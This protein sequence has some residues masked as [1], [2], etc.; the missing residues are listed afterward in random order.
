M[1]VPLVLV[2]AA[3]EPVP[4]PRFETVDASESGRVLALSG[5]G[6]YTVVSSTAASESVPGPGLWRI[7]RR[8]GIFEEETLALVTGHPLGNKRLDVEPD[9]ATAYFNEPLRTTV[10]ADGRFLTY[11]G[12]DGTVH[13]HDRCLVPATRCCPATGWGGGAGPL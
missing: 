7:D 8:D 9:L 2:A 5:N 10:S 1:L 6:F 11:A 3:C 4:H 12:S 13:F